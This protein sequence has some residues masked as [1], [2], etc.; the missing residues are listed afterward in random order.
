MRRTP[1]VVAF[2]REAVVVSTA[3]AAGAYLAVLGTV[4]CAPPSAVDERMA[5]IREAL[6]AEV[7]RR[8]AG[9]GAVPAKFQLDDAHVVEAQIGEALR[10][11]V[12]RTT[13]GHLA[14]NGTFRRTRVIPTKSRVASVRRVAN[15]ASS[16]FAQNRAR[17]NT[18]AIVAQT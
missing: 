7:A 2:A 8:A 14:R 16:N 12:A 13:D 17:H 9:L 3:T 1:S 11:G 5:V 15:A 6:A 4:Q 10:V 18:S